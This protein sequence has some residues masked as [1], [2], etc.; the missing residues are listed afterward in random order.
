MY[1]DQGLPVLKT[2][3]VIG[4]FY[5][6]LAYASYLFINP[7]DYQYTADDYHFKNLNF[8]LKRPLHK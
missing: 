3:L 1:H 5:S 4:I 7:Q 6:G 8:Y 2:L